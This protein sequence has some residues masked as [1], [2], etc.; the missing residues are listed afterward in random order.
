MQTE[1]GPQSESVVHWS[2]EQNAKKLSSTVQRPL[3]PPSV[4]CESLVHEAP[5][6]PESTPGTAL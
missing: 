1:D 6:M 2:N 4:H 5:A 3:T